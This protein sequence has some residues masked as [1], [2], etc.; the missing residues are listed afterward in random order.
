MK[1]SWNSKNSTN[2]WDVSSSFGFKVIVWTR[3]VLL[4]W[5]KAW[6]LKYATFWSRTLMLSSDVMMKTQQTPNPW[7]HCPLDL[8]PDLDP[9]FS[10]DKHTPGR[11]KYILQSRYTCSEN[12]KSLEKMII[13]LWT[14]A[15][16]VLKPLNPSSVSHSTSGNVMWVNKPNNFSCL[17]ADELLF[18]FAVWSSILLKTKLK[19]NEMEMK[20][21]KIN[22]ICVMVVVYMRVNMFI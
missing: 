20:Q 3:L 15:E 11:N 21:V 12:N 14:E 19:R 1:Y 5:G 4:A 16:T 7:A 17:L 10:G 13:K 9:H 22:N 2:S 8:P 6:F 18:S